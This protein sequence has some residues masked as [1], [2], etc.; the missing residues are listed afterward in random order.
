MI[1]KIIILFFLS[2]QAPLVAVTYE[3][4]RAQVIGSSVGTGDT[5]G[6]AY[7]EALSDVP[8]GA[9]VYQ[10]LMHRYTNEWVVTLYWKK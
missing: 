5:K 7:S 6:Q 4:Q 2:L 9:K 8:F 1:K 3:P 10:K